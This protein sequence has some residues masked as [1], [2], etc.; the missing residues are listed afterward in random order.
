MIQIETNYGCRNRRSSAAP[1]RI[2]ATIVRFKMCYSV[3]L[4]GEVISDWILSLKK[5]NL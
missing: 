1:L 4:K 5:Y 3:P 2:L